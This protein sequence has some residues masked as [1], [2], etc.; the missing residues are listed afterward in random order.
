MPL[1]WSEEEAGDG[2]G[3][4][5]YRAAVADDALALTCSTGGDDSS[6]VPLSEMSLSTVQPKSGNNQGEGG[7]G[8][9]SSVRRFAW[10]ASSSADALFSDM[11]ISRG[12]HSKE[13]ARAAW[14]SR[15]ASLHLELAQA[16]FAVTGGLDS[17]P[18]AACGRS[19]TR[20][21]SGDN[22][23]RRSS[24]DSNSVSPDSSP[25]G[26]LDRVSAAMT[27]STMSNSLNNS[28]NGSMNGSSSS[29]VL[30]RRRPA[31][32]SPQRD[33]RGASMDDLGYRRPTL[34][35]LEVAL[36]RAQG[37]PAVL[38]RGMDALNE[39]LED[40]SVRTLAQ[41]GPVPEL[42]FAA[43]R[44]F[45]RDEELLSRALYTTMLLL[46]PRGG[47]EGCLFKGDEMCSLRVEAVASEGV[48]VVLAAMHAHASSRRLQYMGCWA[49]VNMALEASHKQALLDQ[50][51]ISTV[52]VAMDAHKDDEMVQFRA[53]FALINLVTIGG[54]SQTGSRAAAEALSERVVAAT[55]NFL[56][57][58]NVA[59]RGCMVLYNLSLDGA[60][61]EFLRRLQVVPLLQAAAQAHPKDH[62][63]EFVA[64]STASRLENHG[65]PNAMAIA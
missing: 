50:G 18:L 54:V 9:G 7:G 49:L 13:A 64:N 6:S 26:S 41:R 52:C 34:P 15:A 45:P 14:E 10:A 17:A 11:D 44:K 20:T 65:D 28:S 42:L 60:N 4:A 22:E 29:S 61:H 30:P 57:C 24:S 47:S 56:H 21:S 59:G 39:V 51:A 5:N 55:R 53:L 40:E 16:L 23:W 1:P 27:P 19:R 31:S 32:R 33:D 58:L 63:L 46:R 43:M 36:R 35:Q 48:A 62:M 2:D 25:R 38:A 12:S 8:G 37:C 3:R